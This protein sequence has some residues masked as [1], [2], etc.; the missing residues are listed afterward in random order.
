MKIV[1]VTDAWH[2]QTNGVVTTY[3]NT[4]ANL[5]AMGHE[6]EVIEP[7]TY[8][9]VGI[10]TYAEIQLSVNCFD[11]GKRIM[12]ARPDAVHLATEGPLGWAARR[13]LKR[14]G[15]PFTTSVH[16]K[17]PEYARARTGLPLSWG[18]A[19]MRRF[20]RAAVSTL[21]TTE[22]QKR[23]LEG[24]GLRD[25]VAWGRGVDTE[26]FRVD[27][28]FVP[29]PEQPRLLYVGRVAVEKNVEA[30]LEADVPG[31]KVVVGD[32]PQRAQLERRFPDAEFVGYR[33]GR[34]LVD[35]FASA[36][37]FVFPSRT[38]TFGLVMLEAN[39][40]GTPVA[41]FPVTGPRDVVSE[42]VNG[43]LDDDLPAAIR[44]ALTLDRAMCRAHAEANSWRA[45]AQRFLDDLVP[46]RSEPALEWLP[47]SG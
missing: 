18:Y 36:D 23:E 13:F 29:D 42:G 22:T 16:T 35:F 10:P 37:V 38:D 12:D 8:R 3:V 7:S 26:Q 4:I 11:V 28:D 45:V 40:C 2:P 30:F 24:W 17:F 21:C 31:R 15:V 39:A 41:A 44:R 5:E 20:H 32:G 25:L 1:I 19:V 33:Y 6:V 14:V 27:P 43:A 46:W 47:A 9:R 34:E